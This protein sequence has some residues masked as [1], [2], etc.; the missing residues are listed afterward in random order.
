VQEILREDDEKLRELKEEYGEE[1]CGLVTNALIELNEYNPSGRY[2]VPELW[3]FKEKRK[4]TLKEVIQ[5]VLRQWR[6]AKRKR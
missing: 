6:A 5:F 4:G 2:P 3:N 1:V